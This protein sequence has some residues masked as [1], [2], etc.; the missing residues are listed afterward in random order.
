MQG[1]VYLQVWVLAPCWSELY[2]KDFEL[3]L[4]NWVWFNLHSLKYSLD[5]LGK[6]A[7]ACVL[8]STHKNICVGLCSSTNDILWWCKTLQLQWVCADHMGYMCVSAS[9]KCVMRW[10]RYHPY[11]I[12]LLLNIT[13]QPPLQMWAIVSSPPS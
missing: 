4:L 9:W 5:L 10:S 13:L 3:S 12:S 7:C 2:F 1:C 8:V 11:T 6:K